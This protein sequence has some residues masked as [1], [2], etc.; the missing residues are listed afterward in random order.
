MRRNLPPDNALYEQFAGNGTVSAADAGGDLSGDD[1]ESAEDD[2]L[3]VDAEVQKLLDKYG[4]KQ[5]MAVKAK[6]PL[7][8]GKNDKISRASENIF[9]VIKKRYQSLRKRGEFIEGSS[10]RSVKRKRQ[11][12]RR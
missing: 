6:K 4:K 9:S 8:F 11:E 2:E 12:R 1:Y 7:S 10:R 5:K 3:N